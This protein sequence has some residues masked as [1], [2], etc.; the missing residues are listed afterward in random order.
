[1][2]SGAHEERHNISPKYATALYFRIL[3]NPGIQRYTVWATTSVVKKSIQR[4]SKRVV[5]VI[6]QWASCVLF[7]KCLCC[8]VRVGGGAALT[9]GQFR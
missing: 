9:L 6:I 3:Y 1:M 7:W 5:R 8:T 2:L 4:I